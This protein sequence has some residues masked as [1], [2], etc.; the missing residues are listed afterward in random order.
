METEDTETP[1]LPTGKSVISFS[2]LVDHVECSYRHKLKYIDDIDMFEENVNT[3]FG[4]AIHDTCDYYLKNRVMRYEIALDAILEAWEKYKLPNMGEWMTQS[5][6][7]LE[8]VP[9]FLDEKFPGWECFEAEERLEEK[10]DN[11]DD[12]KFKG[13]VDAI[14]KYNGTYYIIDWKTSTKGWND[15]KKKDDNLKMQLVL[16][17]SFWGNKHNIPLDQ[18]KVGFVVLNRDLTNPIRIEFYS[19]DVEETRNKK[20]LNILDNSI[21]MIK[22][23]KYFK[24]WKYSHP[25]QQ[26]NCRFCDY[27]GTQHCP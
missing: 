20:T 26:K 6:A 21:N 16:Y 8:A 5:N 7:L 15:Y 4:K 10:L 18:I 25:W 17:R 19:F 13:Y 14:I 12:V 2:E 11:H 1:S 9:S 24:E 23:G 22:R 3:N 27:N